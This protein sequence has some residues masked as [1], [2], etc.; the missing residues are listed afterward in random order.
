MTAVSV[1]ACSQPEPGSPVPS[2]TE[3]A[4]PSKDPG[5]P[6][7]SNPKNLEAV[8]D[9]CRL[10][11]SE[12]LQQL[13]TTGATSHRPSAWGEDT[14]TWGVDADGLQVYLAPA[15]TT[16]YGLSS[17]LR[18][19]GKSAPDED[20]GGY[21]MV[22]S[23]PATF[24]CGIYVAVNADDVFTVVTDRGDSERPEHQDTCAVAK[25]VAS[26]VLSNLPAQN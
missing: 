20:V 19:T 2:D 6:E 25:Q 15:V 17:V 18:T 12:Q 8:S 14:C 21:P 13:G 26:M 10:L 4:T 24:T 7:V 16:N 3:P 9:P 11:K 5:R 23:D 1:A 22:T